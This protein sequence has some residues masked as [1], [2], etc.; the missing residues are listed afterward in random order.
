MRPAPR[1]EKKFATGLVDPELVATTL[2]HL[3]AGLVEEHA[4][5]AVHS[6]YF[7]DHDQSLLRA[8]LAGVDRRFKLRLRWYGP[9]L[10]LPLP[11][12]AAATVL[13]L[14]VKERYGAASRK[15]VLPLR[16]QA[17]DPPGAA[18]LEALAVDLARSD[19]PLARA[20][21]ALLGEHAAT[22]GNLMPQCL[23]CYERRYF[24]ALDGS[25]ARVTLDY[26]LRGAAWGSS[27]GPVPLA[28]EVLVELKIPVATSLGGDRLA[29]ALPWTPVKSSKYLRVAHALM[30]S[31]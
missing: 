7:D 14:E 26:A 3:A 16:R 19:S 21:R 27:A 6:L 9:P 30:L 28:D 29:R 8:H 18:P 13:Y 2:R 22:L 1:F 24:S 10:S 17:S 31:P 5:R 15:T 12:L 23:V 4:E 20:A 25:G 11:E